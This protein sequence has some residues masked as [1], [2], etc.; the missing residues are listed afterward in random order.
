MT[1]FIEVKD[2]FFAY[3]V[4]KPVLNGLNF[5]IKR[6]EIIALLGP[7]GCGK[8]TLMRLMLGLM[9]PVK[10][11]VLFN[12]QNVSHINHKLFAREVAYVPQVHR[13][14]FPY[15][16][17][18]VVLMGRIP[19]K[20]FFFAYSR[21]DHE[22]ADNIMDRLLIRHL[23]HQPY[24]QISGGERQLTLIARAMAQG[25]HTFYMDEPA[26]GLDYGNQM[27]LLKQ[28]MKLADEGYTFIKSTH[29][30]EH[31]LWI[32]D[33]AVMMKD[34]VIWADGKCS[35]VINTE[36]LMALYNTKINVDCVRD[37]IYVCSPAGVSRHQAEH[38]NATGANWYQTPA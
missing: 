36:N 19:H 35:E 7:N 28:I 32:A 20:G 30:P 16:V 38:V 4:K 23:A 5:S 15:T 18:D 21:Q 9:R 10:G 13:S 33:R 17:E 27:R 6:G 1:G 8:S 34:G 26:T 12:G 24:T 11:A 31:A 2:L 22:L 37:S 3:D 14:S 25:A 29:A